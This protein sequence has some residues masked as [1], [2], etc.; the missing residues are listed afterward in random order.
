MNLPLSAL[1]CL[2]TWALPCIGHAEEPL[3]RLPGSTNPDPAQIAFAKLPVLGGTPAVVCAFDPQWQFQLHNY[4]LFHDR[5]FWCMWSQGPQVEDLPTQHV[6]YATSDDGLHWSESKSL[7][8]S[9]EEGRAY[10]ARGFWLRDGELLALAAYYKGKG[11]FGVDKDLKLQAFAWDK[12]HAEWKPRGVVF[13]DAINNFAPE[14]IST[15]EWM[16]TRRDARFNV[17]MLVGGVQALDDWRSISIIDRL[18]SVHST[19]FSPDEPVWWEQPDQRLIALFRDNGGSDRLFRS[20]STDHGLTWTAPEKT[21]YPNATSK[22][23]SMVTSRGYRLLISNANIKAGR[24]EMYV[25]LSEDGLTFTRL[26]RLD[27]P[28]PQ[29]TTFQYPHAIEQG[30]YV[31]IAY[32]NRKNFIELFRVSLEDLD[33]LRRS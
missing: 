32:S 11:A 22:L 33:A 24:R 26:A 15:G 6:R 23:F 20:I 17:S 9:P 19:G 21:N 10:I 27:L 5:K 1:L 4:L 2:L 12:T 14:K 8:G 18:K 28:S 16:T 13:N 29:P 25:A 30:G 7:T 3:L 31:Y